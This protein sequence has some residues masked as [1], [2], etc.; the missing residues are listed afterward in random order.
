MA[1]K[2]KINPDSERARKSLR[3]RLSCGY[4]RIDCVISPLAGRALSEV[5]IKRE[6]RN[7]TEAIET[8]IQEEQIRLLKGRGKG[9]K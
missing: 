9:K 8:L 4:V 2:K 3:E 7:R 6:F 1:A 5:M